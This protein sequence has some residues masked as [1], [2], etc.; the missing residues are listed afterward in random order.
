MST[1]AL[2][3]VVGYVRRLGACDTHGLTDRQLLDRF[4]AQRDEA[5]FAELVCR[6]GP[7]VLS[8]CRRVLRHAQ[9]AEDAF[10]AA[11]LV[12]ARKADSIRQGDSVGGWLYQVAHRLAVRARLISTRRREVH[13]TLPDVFGAARPS[14]PGVPLDDELQRLPEPYRSAV[15]LCYLE[16]RSQHEAARLLATTPDAVNSRLKRA[17]EWLRTRLARSGVVLSVVAVAEALAARVADAALPPLLARLTARTAIHFVTGQAPACGAS[18]LAAALAQGALHSM[19]PP[20]FKLLSAL[21]L[22]AALATTGALLASAPPGDDPPPPPAPPR[23][24]PQ[25]AAAQEKPAPQPGGK[26]KRQPSVI[27]LWMGGGPSQ[28]ETFDPK[29]GAPNQLLFKSI[30]TTIKDVQFSEN[31][32]QLAR[33]ANRLTVIRSLTHREGDHQRG[34]YMMRTGV[35]V[36]GVLEYPSLGCVLAKELGDGR[37]DLPRYLSTGIPVLAGPGFGPGF[38][39]TQYGAVIIGKGDGG[40]VRAEAAEALVAVAAPVPFAKL[41]LPDAAVFEAV[42]K[43]KGEAH[44]KAVTKAFNLSE[45][46]E[47]VR[48]AYGPGRFGQGCLLAR[49]L[50]ERGVPVVEVTLDGWDTHA[51]IPE[52]MPK[53]CAQLDAGFASL[54]KDLDDRKLLDS[55]LIVWAG[56]F[57]RTPRVNGS[58]GRDHYPQAFTVVLAGAGT[59]RGAVVGKT[60]ADGVKIEER[61]VT[62]PELLAT[63]YRAVGVDATRTNTVPGGPKVPLVEKGTQPVKEALR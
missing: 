31:L 33:L 26:E 13:T 11:F 20:K 53:L 17:R 15:V 43:G 1:A 49:R 8:A 9:D 58:N 35:A 38:L 36:D 19:N 25:Q 52:G 59:K 48:K 32:P 50:V 30:N 40:N 45:E 14:A 54:L 41:P 24:Q 39:G 21:I 44:R 61:P 10:Q 46:K 63:V 34:A 18:A 12:L 5:A 55:T 29:S 16:G 51:N 37:P 47:E 23:S 42:A 4:T 3:A 22:G 60:G 2:G 6:H 57:G 28:F 56:E 62:V 27:I 7:M